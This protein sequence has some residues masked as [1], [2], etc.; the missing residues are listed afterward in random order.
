MFAEIRSWVVN[1]CWSAFS[2]ETWKKKSQ[3]V[4]TLLK[5]TF[6]ISVISLIAVIF[7]Y[8]DIHVWSKPS[9]SVVLVPKE[10]LVEINGALY[11]P[12]K[13]MT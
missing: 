12:I 8:I 13:L 10:T 1:K 4:V 3:L 6:V 2:I 9:G 11:I 5:I 7:A